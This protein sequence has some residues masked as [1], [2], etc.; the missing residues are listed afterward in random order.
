MQ[1][2]TNYTYPVLFIYFLMM[3]L[4]IFLDHII[5]HNLSLALNI[6]S[7]IFQLILMVMYIIPLYIFLEYV[8][9]QQLKYF[10]YQVEIEKYK[11]TLENSTIAAFIYKDNAFLYVSPAFAE[12]F[13]YTRKEI[14]EKP[15]TSYDLLSEEYHEKVSMNVKDRL[16]G[17]KVSSH[18]QVKAKRKDG[19]ELY[20][21]LYPSLQAFNGKKVVVGSVVNVTEK[22]QIQN[23]L[24]KSEKVLSQA[25]K[26]AGILYWEF[27]NVNN[28]LTWS[29]QTY[30]LFGVSPNI[31]PTFEYLL[32]KVHSED[33]DTLIN[34]REKEITG[35]NVTNIYRIIL[36]DGSIRTLHSISQCLLDDN[37]RPIQTIGTM[38]D[39]TDRLVEE[40]KLELTENRYKSLFDNNLDSVFSLDLEGNIITVNEMAIRTFGYSREE[41]I[42]QYLL[43][44]IAPEFRNGAEQLFVQVLSGKP[45]R[46]QI[47]AFHKEGHRVDLDVTVMPIIVKSF[48]TGVFCILKDVTK[49]KEHMKTIEQLAYN[50]YLTGL[51]N[52]RKLLELMHSHIQEAKNHGSMMGIL[53]I[54]LDRLKF[55]NDNLGHDFGDAMIIEAGNRILSCI[56]NEDTLARVGGDEFVLIIPNISEFD[57][58]INIAKRIIEAFKP[59]FYLEE[60]LFRTT[61]SMGI[62]VFPTHGE[63]I[64]ELL[65]KADKA[66]YYVKTRKKNDYK[67]FEDSMVV[68][69]ERKF[70]IQNSIVSSLSNGDFFL[71][72]Q[73]RIDV[74]TGKTSTFE[75][76]LRW[77]HPDLGLITPEEFIPLAEESGDIVLIGE[78]VLNE[79]LR[80]LKHLHLIGNTDVRVS[81][82]VSV[83]Q[84]YQ[85]TLDQAINNMLQRYKLPPKTLELELTESI[86]ISDEQKILDILTNLKSLGVLLSIDDF[87]TGNSS[88]TYLKKLNMDIIKID[89][90][91]VKGV[92]EA[93]ENAAITSAMINLIHDLNMKVVCEGIETE[94]ECQF[95]MDKG[96]DEI[97]GFY[98]SYPL[99]KNDLF[100][101]LQREAIN[102]PRLQYQSKKLGNRG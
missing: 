10:G 34:S 77:K 99:V 28:K 17:K 30:K 35:E 69:E 9:K 84:L 96:S 70:L 91:Y 101:Y 13:G 71:E 15:I 98:V 56:R 7:W 87:G 45:Q 8:K 43:D 58:T 20:L 88:I 3:F 14:Y 26:I 62:S 47:Q 89:R 57:I 63:D 44:L 11:L 74:K 59:G 54:D 29:P 23:E 55:I 61:A 78:W 42:Q 21:D 1:W 85:S 94:E 53:Y 16:D 39:I 19:I 86:L 92:P 24:E 80:T 2:S 75:S 51:P 72:Y 46:I 97:Q 4:T 40:N 76:L 50:D 83:K 60:K 81:V 73:P 5:I 79:S 100:Q 33:R 65:R 49:Q 95:I 68:Q 18:Y 52:R 102:G 36:D 12:L 64:N 67:V 38:Q 32:S 90:S 31:N 66:M 93:K 37:G 25:Q 27:D 48:V 41:M 22:R 6:P 82:N